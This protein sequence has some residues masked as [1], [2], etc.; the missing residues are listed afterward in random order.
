[1]SVSD[2]GCRSSTTEMNQYCGMW[3]DL[4]NR[5]RNLSIDLRKFEMHDRY[6]SDITEYSNT[7]V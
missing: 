5:K 6:L 1:M 2:F 7:G 3:K 4:K